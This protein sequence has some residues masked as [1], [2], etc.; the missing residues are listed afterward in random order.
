MYLPTLQRISFQPYVLQLSIVTVIFGTVKIHE[1]N[2]AQ[3]LDKLPPKGGDLTQ[4]PATASEKCNMLD[5]NK[6]IGLS[7]MLPGH[8]Q[9]S[10]QSWK[11]H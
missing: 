8:H 7:S 11:N 6:H 5:G 1:K 2:T 10:L 4:K 9:Q 3:I